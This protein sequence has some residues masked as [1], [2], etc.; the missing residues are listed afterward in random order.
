M[1]PN[2]ATGTSWSSARGFTII[3]LLIVMTL[4]IIL[5]SIGI[6]IATVTIRK[7]EPPGCIEAMGMN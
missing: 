5:A 4:I 1:A 7:T 2:T 3:E 6:V